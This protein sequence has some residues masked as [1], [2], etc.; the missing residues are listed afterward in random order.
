MA[1][2]DAASGGVRARE[3]VSLACTERAIRGG[4][5]ADKRVVTAQKLIVEPDGEAIHEPCADCGHSTRSVWGYISD[6]RGARAVYFIRWTEGHLERGAQLIVS[7]G[8]WG[9][10]ARPQDRRC[11]GI[12][13]RM[14]DDRP[15]FMVVDATDLP[16]AHEEFLGAK[17]SRDVALA[18]PIATEVFAMLDRLVDDEPRFRAFLVNGR[19]LT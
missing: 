12:E 4:H 15:G 13:C 18:D 8:A 14:G 1:G 19:K 17:L 7:I 6:E 16:W 9:D 10:G 11:V 5:G 3:R 2:F